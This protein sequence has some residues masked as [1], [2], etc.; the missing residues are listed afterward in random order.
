MIDEFKPPI[1]ERTTEE[2]LLI[3]GSEKEWN[4]KAVLLAN[5]ELKT[6]K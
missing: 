1:K 5:N 4:P 6:R 2:L 3:V